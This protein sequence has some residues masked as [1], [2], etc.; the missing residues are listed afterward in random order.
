M[1]DGIEVQHDNEGITIADVQQ[2]VDGTRGE[3]DERLSAMSDE[4]RGLSDSVSQLRSP[5]P[6]EEETNSA[7]VV[8]ISPSQAETAKEAVRI[9]LTEGLICIVLLAALLGVQ[10]FRLFSAGWRRG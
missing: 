2:V 5:E 3:Y 9:G 7:Q 1:S 4:L 6:A 8:Q 10:L